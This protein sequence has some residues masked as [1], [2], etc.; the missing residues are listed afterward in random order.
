MLICTCACALGPSVPVCALVPAGGSLPNGLCPKRIK[1]FSS[2]CDSL[3]SPP[4]LASH[5]PL[6]FLALELRPHTCS[7]LKIH[8]QDHIPMNSEKS[9]AGISRCNGQSSVS[10]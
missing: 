8:K 9:N 10:T 3:K 7:A 6:S 5:L 1:Y 4:H 2:A